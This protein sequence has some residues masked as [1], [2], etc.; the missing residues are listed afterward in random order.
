M[1]T[2]EQEQATDKEL[3]DSDQQDTMPSEAR[4]GNLGNIASFF[5]ATALHR[6]EEVDIVEVASDE[7]Q[8][9]GEGESGRIAPRVGIPALA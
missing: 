6:D 9:A 5:A 8:A 3:G 4:L 1:G 7:R 2:E